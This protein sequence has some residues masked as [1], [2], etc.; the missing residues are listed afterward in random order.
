M[1]SD[2]KVIRKWYKSDMDKNLERDE[3][4]EFLESYKN[5]L[6]NS[7]NE[8]NRAVS[9]AIDYVIWNYQKFKAKRSN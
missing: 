9:I 1:N 4:E 3:F 5:K 6:K 8:M 7:N 2:E